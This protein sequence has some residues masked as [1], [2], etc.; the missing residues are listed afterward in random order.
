MLKYN[1]LIKASI[2]KNYKNSTILNK[3]FYNYFCLQRNQNLKK[4][5]KS[6][7]LIDKR[8]SK[9]STFKTISQI[10]NTKANNVNEKKVLSFYKKFEINLSLK[11][12]YDKFFKKK[13]DIETSISTYVMLG[14]LVS[15]IKSLNLYQKINCILKILDKVL[16]N[17]KNKNSCDAKKLQKLIIIEKLLLNKILNEK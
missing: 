4:L 6:Q 12:S 10:Y 9:D 1:S 8:K 13:S 14:L 17:N 2:K 5:S 7:S 15:N 3:N 11:I 16:L